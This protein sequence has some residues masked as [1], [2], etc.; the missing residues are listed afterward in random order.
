MSSNAN[1]FVQLKELITNLSPLKRIVLLSVTTGTVLLFFFIIKWAGKPEFSPLYNDLD[2]NDAGDVIARLKERKIDYKISSNGAS[3]MIP[4]D[5]IH[6][7]RMDLASMGLPQG[8]GIG[9]EI[10]DNTKLGMT[11]F[12]QNVNYQRALQ[13]ELARTINCFDEVIS[14]RVHIVMP[15]KSLFI[16]DEQ[17][18]TASVVLKLHHGRWLSGNQIQGIIHLVS[19]SISGLQPEN[20]TVID[21][22]GRML[23][24]FKG[25]S[26]EGKISSDQLEFQRKVNKNFEERIKTMLD[27][28]LGENKS[29]VRVSCAIDFKKHEK[30][31]EL[32][33][34]DNKVARSEQILSSVSNG[35]NIVPAGVPGVAS[36]ISLTGTSGNL[37]EKKSQF[38]RKDRTVNYEIGKVV[39]HI[40]EPYGTI[41]RLS[42]AVLV[43]GVYK[44]IVDA[45]NKKSGNKTLNKGSELQYFA[46]SD[47]E[48]NK[49][50]NIVKRAVNFNEERGDRI[51]VVN[52]PFATTESEASDEDLIKEDLLSRIIKNK[53]FIQYTSSALILILMFIF[54]VRPLIKWL[55][56][57]SNENISVLKHLPKTLQEIE[58]EYAYGTNGSGFRDK[59]LDFIKNDGEKSAQ[60]MK[61][62]LKE[63]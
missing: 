51:E 47:E 33:Y 29:I 31:E 61:N 48:M 4:Q 13:G 50:E 49:L 38:E 63:K 32:F 39:N 35:S 60:F 10:F 45:D 12:V 36:N 52:I 18:A 42:V 26:G 30:T 11:E 2:A 40:V 55:T 9:F 41:K 21:N 23:A 24:G 28:A 62:W 57:A 53:I 1:A 44:T 37:P 5:K 22:S 34:P 59:A 56:S 6:E 54:V 27:R 15:S 7:M 16:E 46:R 17:P 20:V 3:I 25:G 19:S 14:S 8:G 58:N 43:D